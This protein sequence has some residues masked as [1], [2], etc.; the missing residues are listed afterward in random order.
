MRKSKED[1]RYDDLG[2]PIKP[3]VSMYKIWEEFNLNYP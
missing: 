2:K 1:K 3:T